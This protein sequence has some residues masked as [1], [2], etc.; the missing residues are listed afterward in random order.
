MLFLFFWISRFPNIFNHSLGL[1]SPYVIS[2]PFEN[3]NGNNCRILHILLCIHH[4]FA[5]CL[6]ILFAICSQY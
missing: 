6:S 1:S 3:A 2:N 4:K 5:V